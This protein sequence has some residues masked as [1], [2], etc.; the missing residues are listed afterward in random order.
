MATATK[1]APLTNEFSAR[2]NDLRT[3]LK[4]SYRDFGKLIGGSASGANESVIFRLCK[5]TAKPEEVNK[6]RPLLAQGLKSHLLSLGNSTDE[7]ITELTKIFNLEEL[8]MA[9]IKRTTLP[10]SVQRKFGLKRDP[11]DKPKPGEA[12]EVFS[13]A[14]LDNVFDR[15]MEA[16]NYQQFVAVIGDIGAGK[17]LM[18]QRVKDACAESQGRTQ[19]LWPRC[20]EMAKVKVASILRFI[21]EAFKQKCPMDSLAR[22]TRLE[23]LLT[24]LYN[25]GKRIAI[26]FD[27]C[28][29]LPDETLTALKN[30]HE[31]GSHFVN[32]LGIVLIGQPSFKAN[33]DK[34]EF[35]EIA[36]RIEII[37]MPTIEKVAFDYA[38]HRIGLAGGDI[39]KIF[40]REAI[41]LLVAHANTPLSLGNLC[42]RAMI[43]AAKYPDPKVTSALLLSKQKEL[44]ITLEPRLMSVKR[45]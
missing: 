8:N 21:L 28:H 39:E 20:E 45:S 23:N 10:P 15:I 18:K 25:D 17:S 43:L 37:E 22:S 16:I 5:G 42:N 33:L 7:V 9:S 31:I 2:L 30:F 14:E 32:F 40:E 35:R 12:F 41:T 6:F 1:A 11:F 19:I 36:E 13:T 44:G 3:S 29:R 26:G 24:Q 27:E 38:S 4:L 34:P